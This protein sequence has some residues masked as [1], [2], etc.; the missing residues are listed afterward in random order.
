MLTLHN[1][2]TFIIQI[3]YIKS[4]TYDVI[5]FYDEYKSDAALKKYKSHDGFL[6]HYRPNLTNLNWRKQ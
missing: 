1:H 6:I 2:N 5:Q 4:R 3:I